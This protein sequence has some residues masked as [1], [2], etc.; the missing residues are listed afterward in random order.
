M[1]GLHIFHQKLSRRS[2]L[3]AERLLVGPAGGIFAG[4]QHELH[5]VWVL[6]R[7]NREPSVASLGEICFLHEAEIVRIE[8]QRLVLIINVDGGPLDPHVLSPCL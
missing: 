2:A 3:A 1:L 6:R 7:G 8:L 5:A 4:L